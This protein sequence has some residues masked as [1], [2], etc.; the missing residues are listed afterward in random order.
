M[1]KIVRIYKLILMNSIYKANPDR[2]KIITIKIQKKVM[3]FTLQMKIFTKEESNISLIG[4][5]QIL[6]FSLNSFFSYKKSGHLSAPNLNPI[7]M[8]CDDE[9]YVYKAIFEFKKLLTPLKCQSYLKKEIKKKKGKVIGQIE[10]SAKKRLFFPLNLLCLFNCQDLNLSLIEL[11][12]FKKIEHLNTFFPKTNQASIKLISRI[13]PKKLDFKKLFLSQ[14]KYQISKANKSYAYQIS[15]TNIQNQIKENK[16]FIK[17]K[18]TSD[19]HLSKNDKTKYLLISNL[20]KIVIS[21]KKCL[22]T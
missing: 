9:E 16:Y 6:L 12:F 4:F 19:Y 8:V 7:E 11:K 2:Q 14:L 5:I 3:W 22:V 21:S 13:V 15:E 10:K 18:Y 20:S 1:P 17:K